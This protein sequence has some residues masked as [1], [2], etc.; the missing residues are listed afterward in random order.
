MRPYR[1]TK[2]IGRCVHS[3]NQQP[4]WMCFCPH[5]HEE[6]AL[7]VQLGN[8]VAAIGQPAHEWGAGVVIHIV[9]IAVTME[10]VAVWP[11]S[12]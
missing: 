2:Y 1:N 9:K 12:W 7:T 8:D 11:H 3:R 5:L 10:A 6:L 4:T